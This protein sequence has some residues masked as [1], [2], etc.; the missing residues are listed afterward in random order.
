MTLRPSLLAFALLLL[1]G[2]AVVLTGTSA[3]GDAVSDKAEKEA[4]AKGQLLWRKV[5]RAGGKPCAACHDRG[6][7][8]LTA[9]RLKAYPKYDTTLRKVVTGQQKLN[10]MIG[11]KGG[12]KPLELGSDDLNALE[13]YV[14]TLE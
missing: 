11:A 8:R 14:S 13:A 12:G 4:V 1:G 9:D 10:Q 7:N 5:W 3:T 2:G 6:P